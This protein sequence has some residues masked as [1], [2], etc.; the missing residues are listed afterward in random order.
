MKTLVIVAHPEI[1]SSATQSFLREGVKDLPDV[2][3]HRVD[4]LTE[5]DVQNERQLLMTADR[6]VFQFPLYWYAAPASLKHWAD[7][8]FSQKLF[9]RGDQYPLQDKEVAVVVTTGKPLNQFQAGGSVGFT[10][11]ELLSSMRAITH[12]AHATWLQT[13]SVTQ[14]SYMSE[15][16]KMTLLINYQRYLTQPAPDNFSHREKWYAQ[17]LQQYLKLA[18]ESESRVLEMIQTEILANHDKIQELQSTLAMIKE[19]EEE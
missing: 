11:D 14:F 15:D 10:L 1:T 8:V 13:F 3:W 5:D 16:Q 12:E 2:L 9:K 19:G 18:P 6:I 4:E 17:R 7:L